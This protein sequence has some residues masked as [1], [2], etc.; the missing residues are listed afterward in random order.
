MIADATGAV[1]AVELRH[2]RVDVERAAWV[3]RTNHYT[4]AADRLPPV[5]HSRRPAR[6]AA[7]PPRR[8]HAAR[9]HPRPPGAGRASLPA[10]RRCR[11]DH[12]RARSG[13]RAR[14]PPASPS[15]LLRAVPWRGFRFLD[16]EWRETHA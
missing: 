4:A 8:W 13:R 2:R 10:C 5:P 6:R 3:A 14:L 16:G 12:H 1:A 15:A 11:A 7:R 9:G